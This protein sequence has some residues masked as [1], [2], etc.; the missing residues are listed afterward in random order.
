MP[1]KPTRLALLIA[2][3]G[4]GM[5]AAERALAEEGDGVA[6]SRVL[7]QADTPPTHRE[8]DE[9]APAGPQQGVEEPASL[10]M[11]LEEPVQEPS[12]PD[13]APSDIAPAPARAE[14]KPL[15]EEV[16]TGE[17]PCAAD[18]LQ[19]RPVEVMAEALTV[20][21]QAASPQADEPSA[22]W[23]AQEHVDKPVTAARPRGFLAALGHAL[24]SLFLGP[25]PAAGPDAVEPPKVMGQLA[26][27]VQE[28]R[29][30]DVLSKRA[31][32]LGE[33][34]AEQQ[35]SPLPGVAVAMSED[36]L[37]HVR[38]GFTAPNG[39][40]VAFGIERLVYVNGEL[41]TT[42]RLNFATQDPLSAAAAG[43][44]NRLAL[45]QEGAAGTVVRAAI[46]TVI[47]NALDGQKIQSLTTINATVNSLQ[48]LR[49][50]QLQSDVTRAIVDSL[51][52]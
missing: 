22:P 1:H 52:R 48:V 10:A 4:L 30:R 29:A 21:P 27:V 46:P 6:H 41:V 20:Q 34:E 31:L 7:S 40:H 43:S 25:A 2:V 36:R 28:S 14:R 15:D 17:P 33:H 3:I 42:T 9:A 8:A 49:G 47:Q 18:P 16:A 32:L 44:A 13:P 45:I 12:S 50:L 37:D 38:G 11:P 51:R 26:L 23:H 5:P 24:R 19:P 35:A 39:L